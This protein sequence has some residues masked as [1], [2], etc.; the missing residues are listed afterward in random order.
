VTYLNLFHLIT[1]EKIKPVT[2]IGFPPSILLIESRKFVAEAIEFR[3][4]YVY[5]VTFQTNQ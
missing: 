2:I 3:Y 4:C 1:I 5:P